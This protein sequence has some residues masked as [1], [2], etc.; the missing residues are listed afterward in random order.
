M[1]A[2][3]NAD[4]RLL[5]LCVLKL[6]SVSDKPEVSTTKHILKYGPLLHHAGTTTLDETQRKTWDNFRI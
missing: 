5:P 6:H 2:S 3:N 1:A 4:E